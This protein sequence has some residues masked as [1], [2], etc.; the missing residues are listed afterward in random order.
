MG[1]DVSIALRDTGQRVAYD[2]AAEAMGIP[3]AIETWGTG[4]PSDWQVRTLWDGGSA[5]RDL[6]EFLNGYSVGRPDADGDAYTGSFLIAPVTLTELGEIRKGLDEAMGSKMRVIENLGLVSDE[7]A[8]EYW[9]DLE[10]GTIDKARSYLSV[11]VVRSVSVPAMRGTIT[12]DDETA[13]VPQSNQSA[14]DAYFKHVTASRNAS[15]A[16]A[17]VAAGE[18][19]EEALGA[20]VADAQR[21]KEEYDAV[22]PE[23]DTVSFHV[24]T[25]DVTTY[26][27][28]ISVES[29]RLDPH[30][31]A[32]FKAGVIDVI[33]EAV[34]DG[35][36][37]EPLY[38]ILAD[39]PGIMLATFARLGEI[40][41][42]ASS[43]HIAELVVQPS[44]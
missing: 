2:R 21:A 24:G 29:E 7:D 19:G 10:R 26:D 27:H 43:A 17:K 4:E 16:K 15:E 40:G 18:I 6:A 41:R 44:W 38:D 1:Y 37:V 5:M 34:D 12:H 32:A 20:I 25:L 9:H 33:R 11:P 30:A 35:Y 8:F 42:A 39:S 22:R 3:H 28:P 36:A 14:W 31:G 13:S 23:Q